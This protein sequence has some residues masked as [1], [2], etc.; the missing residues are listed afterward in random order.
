ME[1]DYELEYL[2]LQNENLKR[3]LDKIDNNQEQVPIDMDEL[4][5]VIE[6]T[7][8]MRHLLQL[9]RNEQINLG[10]AKKIDRILSYAR[11]FD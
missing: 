10:L 7:A 11:Q 6:M 3:Q 4:Q 8:E 2:R 5:S 9:C 1:E